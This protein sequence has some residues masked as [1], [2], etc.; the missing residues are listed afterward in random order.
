MISCS[1]DVVAELCDML[2]RIALVLQAR[3]LE[4]YQMRTQSVDNTCCVSQEI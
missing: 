1:Q 4:G 3:H 2:C